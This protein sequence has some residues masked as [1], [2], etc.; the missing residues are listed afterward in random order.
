M[1]AIRFRQVFDFLV[2]VVMGVAAV[3]IIWRTVATPRAQ[4][5]RA[6]RPPV[7]DLESQQLVTSIADIPVRG[8]PAAPVVLIEFSDFECPFCKKHS[9]DTFDRI[10]KELVATGK[11]RYAFRNLP[12]EMHKHAI[13]AAQAAECAGAQ[14]KFWEMRRRLFARQSELAQAVWLGETANLDLDEN[15]FQQCISAASVDR[16][17]SDQAEAA[18]LG[19]KATPT[20][21][22]GRVDG[23]GVVRVLN[24]IEGARPF[25]V[26]RKVVEDVSSSKSP[27]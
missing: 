8:D 25:E 24:K 21:F 15:S 9:D 7:Q 4:P 19:A 14:G 17:Q 22:V 26:Y 12:L 16:V 27:S 20:F 3:L 10:D 1:R 2:T 13:P 23:R 6:Q 5:L 18:R 11:M